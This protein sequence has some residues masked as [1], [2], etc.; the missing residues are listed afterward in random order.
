[1]SCSVLEKIFIQ[2]FLVDKQKKYIW[3]T[4]QSKSSKIFFQM[5]SNRASKRAKSIIIFVKSLLMYY[6]SRLLSILVRDILS[7]QVLQHAMDALANPENINRLMIVCL[8]EYSTM[9]L[10]SQTVESDPGVQIL[11][12]FTN[13]CQPNTKDLVWRYYINIILETLIS[14]LSCF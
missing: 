12:N 11:N 3:N 7:C 4:A 6:Y 8:D 13:N 9:L 14:K 10:G 5:N 2:Q 1:M